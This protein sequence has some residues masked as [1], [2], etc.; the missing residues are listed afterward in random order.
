MQFNW[1]IQQTDSY[2]FSYLESSKRH[3]IIYYVICDLSI[4][5]GAAEV[6][7]SIV[8]LIILM[9]NYYD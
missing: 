5:M 2:I 1:L 9:C 4:Q 3:N 8:F 7:C 6:H